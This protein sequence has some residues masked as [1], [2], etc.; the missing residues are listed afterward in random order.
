MKIESVVH[1][2]L[3]KIYKLEKQTFGNDAFSKDMLSKLITQDAYFLK[4]VLNKKIIGFIIALH[5]EKDR[6]NI[7]NLLISKKYR[8]NGYGTI[9]LK[10]SIDI[11]KKLDEID[12]IV[13]NVK[14]TNSI[15]ID[16]YRKFNFK[17]IDE[18]ENYYSQM[19]NAYLMELKLYNFL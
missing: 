9:L 14:V 10:R 7:I 16:L 2:D 1:K 18:V 13:L 19:E 12:R 15:A 3:N 11:F 8:R 4:L 6:I 5:D 17:I